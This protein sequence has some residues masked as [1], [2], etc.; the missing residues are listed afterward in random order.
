M[1]GFLLAVRCVREC[2]G[3][4][5]AGGGPL[6][7]RPDRLEVSEKSADDLAQAVAR[8][9]VLARAPFAAHFDEPSLLEEPQVSCRGGPGVLEA[10]GEIARGKLAAALGEEDEHVPPH[11]V[12][13]GGEDRVDVG[14]RGLLHARVS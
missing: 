9:A 10:R 3:G 1:I 13:E 14:E 2:F 6:L 7:I 11:L 12:G 4:L 8:E 5:R